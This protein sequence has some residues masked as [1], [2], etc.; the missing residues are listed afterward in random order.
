[1]GR[2]RGGV[3]GDNLTIQQFNN[4]AI[5]LMMMEKLKTKKR[6]TKNENDIF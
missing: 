1:L 5:D 2:R 6:K 3:L 4:S